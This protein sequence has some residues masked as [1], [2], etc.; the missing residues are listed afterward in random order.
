MLP[1]KQEEM[2]SHLPKEDQGR[3][4]LRRSL[5]K[6]EK[7]HEDLVRE[8]KSSR[9][10]RMSFEKGKYEKLFSNPTVE[11]SCNADKPH[12]LL[13]RLE[14]EAPTNTVEEPTDSGT[15][16]VKQPTLP[17]PMEVPKLCGTCG[18]TLALG[19]PSSI[20]LET[21]ERNIMLRMN[22]FEA[23]QERFEARQERLDRHLSGELRQLR[24][25]FEVLGQLAQ[26]T[27]CSMQLLE[28][29]QPPVPEVDSD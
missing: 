28:P 24:S 13:E 25:A 23:R 14:S 19:S 8:W 29:S 21:L 11:K 1:P 5:T 22:R 10:L 2:F 18:N 26:R 17:E 12:E 6:V 7:S 9:D 4:S 20:P 15:N 3:S 16:I 27:G